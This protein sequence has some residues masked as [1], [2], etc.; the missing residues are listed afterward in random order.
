MKK[1]GP[2]IAAFVLFSFSVVIS[3][4][5]SSWQAMPANQ[6]SDDVEIIIKK[7]DKTV[8]AENQDFVSK[9][10]GISDIGVLLKQKLDSVRK[11]AFCVIES[12]EYEIADGWQEVLNVFEFFEYCR[13][14][15]EAFVRRL[16][17]MPTITGNKDFYEEVDSKPVS[18]PDDDYRSFKYRTSLVPNT[19]AAMKSVVDF[20]YNRF[21]VLLVF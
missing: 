11:T 12:Y 15:P 19:I 16:I 17:I 18:Y 3:I 2:S 6:P 10:C 1:Y 4:F 8:K 21:K 9:E 13:A 20:F 5:I 14:C 7:S